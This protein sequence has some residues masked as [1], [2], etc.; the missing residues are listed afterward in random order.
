MF[1]ILT[2]GIAAVSFCAL[3]QA[4]QSEM[5]D[6]C[7]E[8]GNDREQCECAV[9]VIVDTLEDN[10]LAFMVA[11]MGADTT[12]AEAMLSTAAEHGLDMTGVIGIGQKMA[13]VEPEMR[14]ECGIEDD[15]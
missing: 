7:V 15:E 3:A 13:D 11:M 8:E 10:E 2:A 4:Q 14:A 1:R 9:G 5:V 12:D 6:R